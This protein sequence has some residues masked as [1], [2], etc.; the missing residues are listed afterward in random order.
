M[1]R[2]Y[3][4]LTV[5]ALVGLAASCGRDEPGP[6]GAGTPSPGSPTPYELASPA[7]FPPMNIPA[8]NPLTVEGVELGRFLFFEKRLSGDNSMSCGSCH[9]PALAFSDGLA[10]STGIQGIAGRRSAMP[11]MNLGWASHFFWDGRASTLELQALEP[12]PDP[13]EMHQDWPGAVAKLQADAAYPP[14]FARAFGTQ[15]ITPTLVTRAMAQFMRTL[16]SAD[17][18]YDRFVRGE[19]VLTADEAAGLQ[20]LQLEGGPNGT[21]IPLAGGGFVVGQGGADCFHCHAIGGHLFTDDQFRNNG[22]DPDPFPDNGRGEVTNSVYDHGKFKT[23]TLRNIMLTAPYMHDGRFATIEEV[24]EHYNEGGHPS[25]TV[26]AFMKFTD[27][28]LTLELSETKKR[29]L[30]AF[31]HTLTDETFVNDPRHTDPGPPVP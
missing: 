5:G 13:I 7:H 23:P 20:L 17:S 14:L 3:T 4:L 29:Q 8:D 30:I 15:R 18:K 10:V 19:E 28:E 6:P 25:S 22:L 24:I 26:D 12:V 27:P 11:L 21:R 9:A 2:Y 1:K 31:L 16:V